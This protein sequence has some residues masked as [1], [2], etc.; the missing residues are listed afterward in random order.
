MVFKSRLLLAAPAALALAVSACGGGG[1]GTS[2]PAA[3]GGKGAP[4]KIAGKGRLTACMDVSF[5]PMEY[6][7]AAGTR[8]P[9]GFDVDLVSAIAKQ[10]GVTP[11]FSETSFD[12]L[13]PALSSGRCDVVASGIFI[14]K[15]RTATFPAVAYLKSHSVLLVRKGNPAGITSLQGLSG[16]TAATQKATQYEKTLRALDKQLR[17][18]GKP[19]INVQAYPKASDAVQQLVV[20]RADA[21]YTQDTEAAFRSKA[22]PGQ[23]QVAY[24]DPQGETFGIYTRKGDAELDRG[25]QAALKQM[26]GQGTLAQIAKRW[27]LPASGT[28]L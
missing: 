21:V 14:T 18:Q 23:F 19:G 9:S 8:T 13:L 26:R 11:Q 5:P 28:E 3:S 7:A 20:G 10:W 22:Q 1:G 17:S 15:E 27:G 24:S 2:A 4:A 12:G 6:Y 16:K 25:L